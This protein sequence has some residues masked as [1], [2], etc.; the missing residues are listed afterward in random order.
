MLIQVNTDNHIEGKTSL[1]DWVRNEVDSSLG[2]FQPQ[3]TRVEV[4]LSD[5]NSHKKSEVDKQ[6]TVEARWSGLDPIAVTKNSPTVEE[7]LAAALDS[8]IITLDSRIEKLR[9][10]KRHSSMGSG[11]A[12][13]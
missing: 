9:D 2:R 5:V 3:L 7:A 13:I 4:F 11:G 6:C 1:Q 12:E 10:A 8:M